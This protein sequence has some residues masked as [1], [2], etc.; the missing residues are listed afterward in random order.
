MWTHGPDSSFDPWITQPLHLF[1]PV[2]VKLVF[3]LPLKKMH[4][5]KNNQKRD[6]RILRYPNSQPVTCAHVVW[7]RGS[8]G[9]TP[10]LDSI[11]LR[12]CGHHE[13][14]AR[15]ARAAFD[16]IR[17]K[18]EPAVPGGHEACPGDILQLVLVTFCSC[19]IY[20]YMNF[21]CILMIPTPIEGEGGGGTKPTCRIPFFFAW[22]PWDSDPT[23]RMEL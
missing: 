9:T 10:V 22:N 13:V 17:F 1:K 6:S 12:Q 4:A 2:W 18:G 21:I 5:N 14:R 8:T 20:I 16:I 7:G 23:P 15:A 19:L 11:N 3:T